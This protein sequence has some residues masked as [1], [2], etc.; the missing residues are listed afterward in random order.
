MKKTTLFLLALFVPLLLSSSI[1]LG[2]NHPEFRL[3]I[4]YGFF[5]SVKVFIVKPAIQQYILNK[6][7]NQTMRSNDSGWIYSYDA[8]FSNPTVVGFDL[9][10]SRS[11]FL[12]PGPNNGS[13]IQIRGLNLTISLDASIKANSIIST[14]GKC[15]FT[16]LSM[17]ADVGIAFNPNPTKDNMYISISSASLSFAKT[18]VSFDTT[19]GSIAASIINFIV[20]NLAYSTVTSAIT[21]FLTGDL[22]SQLKSMT[23]NGIQTSFDKFNITVTIPEQPI[24]YVTP[25]QNYTDIGLQLS[26]VNNQTGEKAPSFYDEVIVDHKLNDQQVQ[27]LL[28]SNLL[29]QVGWI[30]QQLGLISATLSNKQMPADA[31]ISLNTTALKILLPGLATKFGTG[32]GIYVVLKQGAN[33]P[34]LYARDTRFIGLLNTNIE[35]WVDTDSSQYPDQGFEN[36]TTCVKGLSFSNSLLLEVG[37]FKI[38]AA[39]LGVNILNLDMVDLSIIDGEGFNAQDLKTSFNNLLKGFI[40]TINS[41]LKS[42]IVLP[43]IGLFGIK[44]VTLNVNKNFLSAEVSLKSPSEEHLR[45]LEEYVRRL[46]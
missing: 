18:S 45:V 11:H 29:N 4:D 19:F 17:D 42:G 15:N 3:S 25:S 41:Q 21:N 35:F 33:A 2:A 22:S 34:Q 44:D 46:L 13:L 8:N 30:V 6:P 24:V 39:T 12:A 9:D 1:A 37:L 28:A 32:K 38:D 14:Q 16:L 7:I 23:L 36:C 40:P 5:D 26:I 27:I 43:V 31:P 20:N 10:W